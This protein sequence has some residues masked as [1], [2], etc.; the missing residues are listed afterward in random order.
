LYKC[1]ISSLTLRKE[2]KL[3]MFENNVLRKIFG[4]KKQEVT[5]KFRI[6]HNRKFYYL[7]R[8]PSTVRVMKSRQL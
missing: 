2:H 8:S 3:E 5:G 4:S 7:Y 1:E 6:L